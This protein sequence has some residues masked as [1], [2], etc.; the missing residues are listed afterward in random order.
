[1][2]IH[3]VYLFTVFQLLINFNLLFELLPI[4][5]YFPVVITWRWTIYPW[6]FPQGSWFNRSSVEARKFAFLINFW[7]MPLLLAWDHI[8]EAWFM[9][10]H[11]MSGVQESEVHSKIIFFTT[12]CIFSPNIA[13]P[14]HMV[15]PQINKQ[16]FIF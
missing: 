3:S 9:H 11:L 6:R 8:L 15:K 10:S 2:S 1:M 16:E 5:I 7:V 13:L 4:A 12:T 14:I